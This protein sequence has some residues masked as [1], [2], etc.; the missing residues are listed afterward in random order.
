MQLPTGFI[1]K[2]TRLLGEQAPAFFAS[3]DAPVQKGYRVNPLKENNKP[4]TTPDDGSVTYTEFGHYGQVNGHSIDH[5]SGMVYSQEPSA[6]FVGEV[7]HPH[8][9]EIVLDLS[10]APG[11]KTTHLASFMRQEGL[12]V[13]NEIFKKRAQVLTENVERFGISNAVVTNESPERLAQQL[14][15]FFDRIVVDAPCSGEGMFRKDPAA[16]QYWDEDYPAKCAALQRT[17]L[18]EAVKMLKPDAELIYS[19]CT[20]APEEDEQMIAWLLATYPQLELLPI[21]KPVGMDDGRPEW[22]DGNPEL[23]KT[24]RLFPHHM[25]GEG[26]FVAKMRWHDETAT[27]QKLKPVKTNLTKEQIVLWQ[28]FANDNLLVPMVGTLLTFGDQLYCVPSQMADFGHL[29]IMRPG[30][31]LG[32]YKK[33]R[34]EPSLALGLALQPSQVKKTV[35]IDDQQWANYVHG[36]T[37]SLAT[38]PVDGNGWYEVVINDNGFG[39]AKVVGA[40]LKNF[41]PKGLRFLAATTQNSNDE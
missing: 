7:A 23:T 13:S 24:A 12:L 35:V 21:E 29:S 33:K 11:G 8:P 40:T 32:T 39:F 6:M 2:Y 28:D 20:F 1:E 30:L 19:T 10:A 14:P 38:A 15:G 16:M 31:H 4:A 17:I 18:A 41:Y 34:F 36:D 37:V 27:E 3:F 26:H 22:A 9:G 25:N 5:A